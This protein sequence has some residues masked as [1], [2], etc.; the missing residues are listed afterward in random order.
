MI[1]EYDNASARLVSWYSKYRELQSIR[2][3]KVSLYLDTK[4]VDTELNRIRAIFS[5]LNAIR[6][7]LKSGNDGFIG[8]LGSRG[9]GVDT[10][11]Y[12]NVKKTANEE[13]AAREKIAKQAEKFVENEI[14]A[15]QRRNEHRLKY[16]DRE[17]KSLQS[18]A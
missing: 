14:K 13:I 7:G 15:E 6:Q 10:G 2:N 5:E 4:D 12:N 16:I 1:R 9:T 8:M 3:K 11:I 18:N 17:G